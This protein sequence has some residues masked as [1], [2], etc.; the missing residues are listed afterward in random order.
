MTL[1]YVT[2]KTVVLVG[3]TRIH[4]KLLWTQHLADTGQGA[5]SPMLACPG[6]LFTLLHCI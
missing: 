1:H 5:K 2:V 6:A 3:L 4:A